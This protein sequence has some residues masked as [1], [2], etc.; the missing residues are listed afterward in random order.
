M[1]PVSQPEQAPDLL[2]SWGNGTSIY[3][4]HLGHSRGP[5]LVVIG[6]TS[7]LEIQTQAEA[8]LHRLRSRVVWGILGTHRPQ[9]QC[10][11]RSAVYGFRC[12]LS[13]VDSSSLFETYHQASEGSRMSV[14]PCCN[15]V[16]CAGCWRHGCDLCC[17]LRSPQRSRSGILTDYLLQL[18][19]CSCSKNILT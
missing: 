10:R 14:L 8:L 9:I 11:P 16:L 12:L 2:G 4:S 19:I 7:L 3:C 1:T 18:I 15:H 5:G 6:T 13:G 17:S